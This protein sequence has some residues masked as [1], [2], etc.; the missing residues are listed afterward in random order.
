M[1]TNCS[2]SSSSSAPNG[3]SAPQS[4]GLFQTC[5][6]LYRSLLF[7]RR[8]TP[9]APL[10]VHK[11]SCTLSPPFLSGILH[12]WT[13]GRSWLCHPCLLRLSPTIWFPTPQQGPEAT[14]TRVPENLRLLNPNMT[15]AIPSKIWLPPTSSGCP[16]G[17]VASIS[18]LT[19]NLSWTPDPKSLL[20]SYTLPLS[21]YSGCHP[22]HPVSQLSWATSPPPANSYFPT[23][24]VLHRL[25]AE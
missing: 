23:I 5:S 17:P 20:A 9:W 2:F 6:L 8:H 14:P 13:S 22:D 15:P 1:G 21:P 10:S 4:Y 24:P 12:C 7:S 3:C 18:V 19:P 16:S 25:G 11:L